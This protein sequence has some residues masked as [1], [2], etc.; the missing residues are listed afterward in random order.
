MML[1]FGVMKKVE[2][3]SRQ[4]QRDCGCFREYGWMDGVVGRC[5]QAFL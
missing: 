5:S 3:G 2:A 1:E 4:Q